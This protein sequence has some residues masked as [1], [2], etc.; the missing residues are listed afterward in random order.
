MIAGK[1]YSPFENA[2]LSAGAA[3][4]ATNTIYLYPFRLALPVTVT[5]IV[6]KTGTG[7]A[8]SSVKS[9]IWANSPIS[10]RPIGAPLIADNTGQATTGSAA[11]IE[12]DTTDAFLPAGWYW[13]GTKYTGTLPTMVGFSGTGFNAGRDIGDDTSAI[14]SPLTGLSFADTYSNSM[15][16]FTEGA[17]FTDL[18]SAQCAAIAFKL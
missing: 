4:G 15:P 1:Y 9:G 12:V 5:K 10:A 16:T 17:S 14:F 11:V 2:V 3:P 13:G 8:G 6:L 18:H 7:G